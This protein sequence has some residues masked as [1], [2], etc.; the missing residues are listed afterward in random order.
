MD[1]MRKKIS[2]IGGDLRQIY[3]ARNLM[4]QGY[5]VRMYGFEHTQAEDCFAFCDLSYALVEAECVLLPL[6]VT[7]DGSTLSMPLSQQKL[8]LKELFS[9]IS[10]NTTVFCGMAEKLP[11]CYR[12]AVV[13]YAKDEGFLLKNAYLTAEAALEIAIANTPV[14]L[15]GASVLITGYGRI[16]FF[17]ARMLHFLGA[18]TYVASRNMSHLAKIELEGC[19]P[20]SYETLSSVLPKME[21]IF[22]TA[23]TLIFD[24]SFICEISKESLFVDLASLPGGID[25]EAAKKRGVSVLHAL[26]LPGKVAPVSSGKIVADTI[27]RLLSHK[28][29]NK[30]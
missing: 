30:E 4:E 25:Q 8:T 17:L 16:G 29:C 6:P 9:K 21:I 13:D 19:I 22:N 7:R 28:N 1:K 12:E 23:P 5:D 26:S 20:V 2:V 15:F 14:S 11:V 24:D 18:E 27:L 10:K 3:A